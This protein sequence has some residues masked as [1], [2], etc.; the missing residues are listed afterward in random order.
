MT[1]FKMLSGQLDEQLAKWTQIKKDEVPKIGATIKQLD[2]PV[3]L[4]DEKRD[5]GK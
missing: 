4:I 2:L 1:S 3:L 5:A